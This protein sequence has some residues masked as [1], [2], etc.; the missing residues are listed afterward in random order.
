MALLAAKL[1]RHLRAQAARQAAAQ[2]D[3]LR[4]YFE[5]PETGNTIIRT[6]QQ[7]APIPRAYITQHSRLIVACWIR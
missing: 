3:V 4:E 2:G 1:S 5:E 6:T 7:V